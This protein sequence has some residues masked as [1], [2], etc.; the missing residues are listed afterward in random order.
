MNEL[1][2]F[3][4]GKFED[5]E[6]AADNELVNLQS[7]QRLYCSLIRYYEPFSEKREEKRAHRSL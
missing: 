6:C 3:D 5:G 1:F 2:Q 7:D 4:S